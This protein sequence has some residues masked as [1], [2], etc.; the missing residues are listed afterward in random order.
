MTL[1]KSQKRFNDNLIKLSEGDEYEKCID[2]WKFTDIYIEDDNYK[3]N[4]LCG[5]PLKHQYYYINQK[6]G[7]IICS[8]K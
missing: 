8:G 5:K 1:T 2:E 3:N 7:K 6:T 4:C